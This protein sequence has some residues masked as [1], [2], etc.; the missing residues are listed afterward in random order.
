MDSAA[1]FLF[2]IVVYM[3]ELIPIKTVRQ[4]LVY[5]T[6]RSSCCRGFVL[7]TLTLGCLAFSLAA[8]AATDG[9]VGNG[10]TAE[11][12]RS[13]TRG[14]NDTAMGFQAL[15]SNT[16]GTSNTATGFNALVF[17][18]SGSENTANGLDALF[19]NT[20]GSFNTAT[21]FNALFNNTT[22]GDNTADGLFTLVNNTTGGG[23]TATGDGALF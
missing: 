8:Q 16:T 10:S 9:D 23:N 7:T 22:G 14:S 1:R 21:G 15:F 18:T 2:K 4:S 12:T 17:N 20:T 3:N 13:L 5:F 6:K 11:G 19:S